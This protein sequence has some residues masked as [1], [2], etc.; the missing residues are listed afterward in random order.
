M[1][2]VLPFSAEQMRKFVFN[3]YWADELISAGKRDE[4]V[5]QRAEAGARDLLQRLS[6]QSNLNA[7][8]VNPLLLTMIATVHRYR[9][10]LPGRRVGLYTE[11]CDVLLGHWREAKGMQDPLALRLLSGE[12]RDGDTV[13]VDEVNDKLV[14]SK[15]GQ[16]A[17]AA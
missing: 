3:W 6:S 10:A 17:R 11:I 13:V 2:E 15:D 8:T 5:R 4:G 14:F 9:G 7:L 12:F 16:M 1:L